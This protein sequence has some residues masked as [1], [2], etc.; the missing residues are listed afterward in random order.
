VRMRNGKIEIYKCKLPMNNFNNCSRMP[1][2]CKGSCISCQKRKLSLLSE[3]NPAELAQMDKNR[4]AVEY[5]TGEIIFKEGNKPQGLLCLNK[6]KVKITRTG[7]S[8]NE[9]IV[10]LKKPVDF[11]GFEAFMGEYNYLTSATALEDVSIC[12]VD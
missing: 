5:K 6:G 10:G 8:G 12:V 1:E 3:L 7:L 9:Q 2:K 4:Y 11:I